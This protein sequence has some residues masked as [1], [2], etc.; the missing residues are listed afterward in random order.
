MSKHTPG[1]WKVRNQYWIVG[2]DGGSICKTEYAD[3]IAVKSREENARLIA[4]APDLL[5]ALRVLT[6]EA[7][8]FSVDGVYFHE[9]CFGH[10]GLDMAYDAIE[11]ATGET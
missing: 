6:Q 1:P 9:K 3:G 11:K 5:E 4:A 10:K 2:P 8:S 7:D